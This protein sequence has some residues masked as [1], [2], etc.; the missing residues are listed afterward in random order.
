MNWVCRFSANAEQDLR[1]LP[2]TIQKRMARVL[3]EMVADPFHDLAE[4]R[5][6]KPRQIGNRE[7][8]RPGGQSQNASTKAT[9][10]TAV[11]PIASW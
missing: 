7:D 8:G 9:T 2:R 4:V 6:H 1:G 3:T 10:A 5:Q 11:M